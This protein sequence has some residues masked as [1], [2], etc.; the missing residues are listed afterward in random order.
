V[1]NSQRSIRDIVTR[2]IALL[3]WL[4]LAGVL[5]LPAAIYGIGQS[6]FGAYGGGTFV[7]FYRDLHYLLRVGEPVALYLVASPYLFW[8]TL[9]L[10]V[11]AFRRSAAPSL[12]EAEGTH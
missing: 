11:W 3:L 12:P 9:R 8:Q 7:D 4:G 5:I 6:I 1:S 10:T 2:E